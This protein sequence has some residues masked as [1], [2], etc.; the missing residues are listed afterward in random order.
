MELAG[1]SLDV[2]HSSSEAYTIE[3]LYSMNSKTEGGIFSGT[4]TAFKGE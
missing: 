3:G 1:S 4:L 2:S